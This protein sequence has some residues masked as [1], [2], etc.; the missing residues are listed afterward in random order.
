MWLH[1]CDYTYR[2]KNYGRNII[3]N[4]GSQLKKDE[5]FIWGTIHNLRNSQEKIVLAYLLLGASFVDA[6]SKWLW[7]MWERQT[8]RTGQAAGQLRSGL[9]ALASSHKKVLQVGFELGSFPML[10]SEQVLESLGKPQSR[11]LM[12]RLKT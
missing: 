10:S 8:E 12:T 1:R 11:V 4:I 9:A 3:L 6:N 7:E 2:H 5:V